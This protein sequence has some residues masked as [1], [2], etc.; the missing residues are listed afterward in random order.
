MSAK[1]VSVIIVS[2]NVCDLLAECLVSVLGSADDVPCDVTVVDNVSGDGTV[3][4]LR[5]RFPTVRLIANEDNVGFA[6]ANNQGLRGAI[7]SPYVLLLNPDAVVRPGAVAALLDAMYGNE[8]IGILGPRIVNPDGT[9]QSGPLFFPT[10]TSTMLGTS[11]GSRRRRQPPRSG[12]AEADWVLGACMMVRQDLIREIGFMDEGYFLYGEEKDWCFRA[13]QAGWRVG[14]LETTEVVHYGGQSTNQRAPESYRA[15][16]DSQVRFY[17]RFYPRSHTRAFLGT[18]L[19]QAGVR[20]VIARALAMVD[21][22]RRD[23]WRG[24]SLTYAAGSRRAW[25]HL[26]GRGKGDA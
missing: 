23:E 20:R 4:M 9:L 25:E 3:A 17:E 24:R 6:A 12:I 1:P 13:K 7:H 10:L 21:A 16:V 2:Y 5:D 15:F 19:V 8:D 22:R 14:V 18:T 26:V 11:A